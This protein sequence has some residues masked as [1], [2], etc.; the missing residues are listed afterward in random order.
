MFYSHDEATMLRNIET[1][2]FHVTKIEDK[3]C[4][5]LL[6]YFP[7]EWHNHIKQAFRFGDEAMINSLQIFQLNNA[8][9]EHRTDFT[10]ECLKIANYDNQ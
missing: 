3:R 5:K 10:Y 6:Q 1:G 8:W 2:Q 9:K 4:D 7:S